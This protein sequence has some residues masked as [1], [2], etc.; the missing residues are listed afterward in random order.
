VP[1][2]YFF[3]CVYTAPAATAATATADAAAVVVAAATA[4]SGDVS[5]V[6]VVVVVVVGGRGVARD[7]WAVGHALLHAVEKLLRSCHRCPCLS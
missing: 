4:T 3:L 5:F 7:E 2:V 1:Q 6:V